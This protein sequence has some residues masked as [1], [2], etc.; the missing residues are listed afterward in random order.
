M[1]RQA[2]LYTAEG[3]AYTTASTTRHA[4]LRMQGPLKTYY[5]LLKHHGN[6]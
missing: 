5:E 4:E 6:R 2:Q 1:L 3:Q